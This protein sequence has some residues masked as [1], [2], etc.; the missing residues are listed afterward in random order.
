M[1][2]AE[3]LTELIVKVKALDMAAVHAE[4]A[5]QQQTATA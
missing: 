3:A 4:A 5:K 1:L 2:P